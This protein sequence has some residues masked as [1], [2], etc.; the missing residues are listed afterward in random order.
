MVIDLDNLLSKRRIPKPKGIC[1]ALM[2]RFLFDARFDSGNRMSIEN[3]SWQ[4]GG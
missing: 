1:K 3:L 4:S 2:K